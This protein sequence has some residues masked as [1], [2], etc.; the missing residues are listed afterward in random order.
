MQQLMQAPMRLSMQHKLAILCVSAIE[1]ALAQVAKQNPQLSSQA[2]LLKGNV[3]KIELKQLPWPLYFICEQQILVLSEYHGDVNVSVQA[4]AAT[5][6]KVTEGANLTELIKSE[7][8]VLDG[9]LNVLQQFSQYLQ[10]LKFDFAEPISK[11][12][13]D[14][15]THLLQT[16]LQFA[17]QRL[18]KLLTASQTHLSELAHEEYRLAPH[19]IEYI[20][21]CDNIDEQSS[22]LNDLEQ[23]ISRLKDQLTR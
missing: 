19:K 22:E 14:V 5:M 16:G 8:L 23:Q 13:G 7:K 10:Q 21:F 12:I 4:D 2:R 11:Y 20:A 6:Y 17:E 18:K 1:T 9:D 15:P 3:I